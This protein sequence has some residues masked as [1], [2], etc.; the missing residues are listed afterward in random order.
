MRFHLHSVLDE[1]QM[2]REYATRHA[3]ASHKGQ[4]ETHAPIPALPT[5]QGRDPP[6]KKTASTAESMGG[7]KEADVSKASRRKQMCDLFR[8]PHDGTPQT[9]APHVCSHL[10]T[11]GQPQKTQASVDAHAHVLLQATDSRPVPV[12]LLG[13][14]VRLRP[15]TPAEGM[16]VSSL[17]DQSDP[18]GVQI[19]SRKCQRAFAHHLGTRQEKLV[20]QLRT[21]PEPKKTTPLSVWEKHGE[22][23]S[24][25]GTTPVP[26]R[27]RSDWDCFHDFVHWTFFRLLYLHLSHTMYVIEEDSPTIMIPCCLAFLN[28]LVG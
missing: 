28:F 9:G 18:R 25:I 26:F 2:L 10:S 16:E 17:S 4:R 1:F 27:F 11:P 3:L 15:C 21:L 19:L 5:K 22:H 23:I 12:H 8:V 6:E 7:E 13:H 20:R 24:Q 14:A